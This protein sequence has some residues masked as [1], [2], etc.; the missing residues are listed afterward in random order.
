[1]VRFV[2]QSL[3]S[4][5][6]AMDGLGFDEQQEATRRRGGGGGG[7]EEEES[8]GS[9]ACWRFFVSRFSSFFSVTPRRRRPSNLASFRFCRS[10]NPSNLSRA[11]PFNN[12]SFPRPSAGGGG[13][14][15]E[16]GEAG[17]G[18]AWE[19]FRRRKQDQQDLWGAPIPQ[20]SLSSERR[21]KSVLDPIR[22]G[23]SN[24]VEERRSLTSFSSFNFFVLGV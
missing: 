6:T 16:S 23:A 14:N 11:K 3:R 7:G 24:E 21:R 5:S 15:S 8:S 12:D 18:G 17:A 13:R 10:Y 9:W 1:M 20:V 22:F 4:S 2:L 19:E